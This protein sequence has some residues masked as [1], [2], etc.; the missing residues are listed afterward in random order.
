MAK[1]V[2]QLQ[3]VLRHR[4]RVEQDRQRELALAIAAQ[5]A[6]QTQIRQLDE[7]V[8]AALTDLRTNHLVGVV[9]LPF[10]TAHRRFM[11]SMQRQGLGLLEKLRQ[12]QAKVTQAQ[13]F[14]SEAT[15]DRKMMEKLRQ[16]QHQRWTATLA[17]KER[18]DADEVA[19]Q[20]SFRA[21]IDDAQPA[22]PDEP[23]VLDPAGLGAAASAKERP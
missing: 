4:E 6:V 1:F 7:S 22:P 5:A 19:M 13:A 9:N 3:A 15:R 17:A 21:A 11:L 18:A 20:M 2:F 14:L 10:L 23:P 16:R 12:E 8:Q